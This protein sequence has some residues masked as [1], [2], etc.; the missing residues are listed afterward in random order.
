MKISY[1]KKR[2]LSSLLKETKIKNKKLDNVFLILFKK[3][4][5]E[6]AKEIRIL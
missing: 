3:I 1:I 2:L 4:I 5:Y 6:N